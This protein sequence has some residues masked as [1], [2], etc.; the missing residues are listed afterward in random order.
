MNLQE[1]LAKIT[2]RS[3]E[4]KIDLTLKRI[5]K[6]LKLLSL[7]RIDAIT[8]KVAGTNGKGSTCNALKQIYTDSGYKVA[9]Y[10]SPHIFHFQERLTINDSVVSESEWIKAFESIDKIA[11]ECNLTYFEN[12]T[13][14]AFWLISKYEIDLAILEIGLG[15]RFDAVNSIPADIGIITSIGLDHTDF[16]GNDLKSI[17]Y[18]KAGILSANMTSIYCGDVENET[19][20]SVAV[21]NKCKLYTIK[22]DFSWIITDGE[23]VYQDNKHGSLTIPKP[24]IHPDVA[25]G[26]IKT[27]MYAAKYF[28]VTK[29]ALSKNIRDIKQIGRCQIIID[30]VPLIIDVSHNVAAVR[31]LVNFVQENYPNKNI[32]LVFG[33]LATK[34]Y[35]G[36]IKSCEDLNANWYVAPPNALMP[37]DCYDLSFPDHTCVEYKETITEAFL[38]AY[39]DAEK[40][41]VIIAFGSFYV[42][43]EALQALTHFKNEGIINCH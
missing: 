38:K 11:S 29:E 37:R 8:I 21:E 18:E 28:Y 9:C 40:D 26:I 16:L 4:N 14:A 42:V 10:T 27:I 35:K 20:E 12:I 6:S 24:N 1:W 3:S 36:I 5:Q 34:D 2:E 30:K 13:L 22:E 33:C 19:I 17:A 15:G 39:E 31:Y 43:S 7:K 32:K 25:A 41:D 23:Y